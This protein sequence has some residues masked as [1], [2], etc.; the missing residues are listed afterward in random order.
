MIQKRFSYTGFGILL[1]LL[2]AG[3]Y[4]QI[5][6]ST[7]SNVPMIGSGQMPTAI[8]GDDQVP[9]NVFQMRIAAGARFDDNAVLGSAGQRS[10]IGY[11][12][13][14]SLAFVQTLRRLD[15]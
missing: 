14:P 15:W 11:S 7:Q 8:P 6:G 13:T 3:S 9:T 10:D 12:F 2:P 5:G 4:A 1:L